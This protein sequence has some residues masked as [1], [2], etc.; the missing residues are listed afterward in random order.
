MSVSSPSSSIRYLQPA[1]SAVEA[2]D[3]SEGP[4]TASWI[5][6]NLRGSDEV[7][8]LD[9]HV[10]R[11]CR[12]MNLFPDVVSLPRDYDGLEAR[13]LSFADR[14]GVKPSLLDAVMWTEVRGGI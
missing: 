4:K 9:V 11:A 12:A 6:R 13:F 1:S 8:I 5:V 3:T 14:I 7:A 2:S 10:I